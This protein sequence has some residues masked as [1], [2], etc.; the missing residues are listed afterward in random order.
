MVVRLGLTIFHIKTISAFFNKTDSWIF[1]LI[2]T[3]IDTNNIHYHEPLQ[4]Q[5]YL[6]KYHH[7]VVYLSRKVCIT[8]TIELVFCIFHP[9][10]RVCIRDPVFLLLE[11]LPYLRPTA[12][13]STLEWSSIQG[14]NVAEVALVDIPVNYQELWIHK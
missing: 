10:V 2:F 9:G 8:Y 1:C 7:F 11:I 3:R 14:Q 12:P 6:I 4:I 13:A 5:Q